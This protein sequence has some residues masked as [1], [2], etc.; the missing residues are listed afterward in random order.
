MNWSKLFLFLL[1]LVLPP[2]IFCKIFM[3]HSDTLVDVEQASF[4]G[5]IETT[6][7]LFYFFPFPIFYLKLVQKKNLKKK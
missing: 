1:Q 4:A 3:S 6:T 2:Q 7:L 5:C